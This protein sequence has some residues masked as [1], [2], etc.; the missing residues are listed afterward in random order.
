MGSFG[1]RLRNGVVSLIATIGILAAVILSGGHAGAGEI[2]IYRVSE[3]PSV[4]SVDG[5]ALRIIAPDL[6]FML[7]EEQ[8]SFEALRSRSDHPDWKRVER[9]VFNRGVSDL[10]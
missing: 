2:P 10:D 4:R 9:T 5:A 3:H 7:V 8:I 1:Q 6:E